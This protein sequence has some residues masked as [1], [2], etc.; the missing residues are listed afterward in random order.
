MKRP[1]FA[2]SSAD[3]LARRTWY[4]MAL[5][6]ALL[7]AWLAFQHQEIVFSEREVDGVLYQSKV[8]CGYGFAMV[9]A[10]RFDAD[11]PGASTQAECLKFGRTRVA[12][13]G[14]F[15]AAASVLMYVGRRYGKEPPRPI[16]SELP[17]LPKG[18]R[19]VEGR[20]A[21]TPDADGK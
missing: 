6:V 16:R 18:E 4:S 17:D 15:L 20:K 8:E 7:A 13:V 5:L 9:F 3:M 12:E 19:G 10:G 11:V 2:Y 21:R 14:G 1:R